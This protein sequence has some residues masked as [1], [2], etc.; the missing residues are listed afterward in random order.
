MG[1]GGLGTILVWIVPLVL[2]GLLLSP[3]SAARAMSIG[4]ASVVG[5]TLR[6]RKADIG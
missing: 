6:L 5:N 2:L 4:S 1:L 3:L